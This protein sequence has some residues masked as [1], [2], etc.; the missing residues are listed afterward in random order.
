MSLGRVLSEIGRTKG[1]TMDRQNVVIRTD[2]GADL[3]VWTSGPSDADAFLLVHGFS[4]DHSTWDPLTE[5]LVADGNYVVTLDTRGHG[6][7][8]LGTAPPTIDR[9]LSDLRQV[10]E[11]LGLRRVHLAGHSFGAVIALASRVSGDLAGS[12][13]T[14]TAIGGTEKSI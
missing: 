1:S 8:T 5:G 7:S 12:V 13:K 11:E 6:E 14:V 9:Y 2:D 3:S 4:L 10:I